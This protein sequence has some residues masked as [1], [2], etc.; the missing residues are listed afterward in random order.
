M[1][2]SLVSLIMGRQQGELIRLHDQKLGNTGS[3]PIALWSSRDALELHRSLS[4]RPR[5]KQ[6]GG[7]WRARL[8]GRRRSGSVVPVGLTDA[9]VPGPPAEAPLP[10]A[11]RGPWAPAAPRTATE[12]S[13]ARLEAAGPPEGSPFQRTSALVGD[14]EW[15]PLLIAS[16]FSPIEGVEGEC[17][18]QELEQRKAALLSLLPRAERG[19]RGK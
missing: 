12:A 11:L 9:V 14:D 6:G 13:R 2:P 7:T 8:R 3:E 4:R 18:Q 5:G 17:R 1:A 19:A 10:Q 16:F 15:A